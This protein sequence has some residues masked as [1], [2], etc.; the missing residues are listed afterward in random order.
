MGQKDDLV[1][2]QVRGKKD[3]NGSVGKKQGGN[4]KT[5][6]EGNQEERER[7]KGDKRSKKFRKL[8]EGGGKMRT[9]NK[10]NLVT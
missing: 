4:G 6:P 2:R 7:K 1:R 5:G 10:N 9:S 3:A 8:H